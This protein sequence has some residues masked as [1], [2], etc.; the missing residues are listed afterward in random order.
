[1]DAIIW[2]LHAMPILLE[3]T[4]ATTIS[5]FRGIEIPQEPTLYDRYRNMKTGSQ[6]IFSISDA[7][8]RV[9]PAVVD[10]NSQSF[11]D[12]QALAMVT[13]VAEL[14]IINKE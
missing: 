12:L 10:R 11:K 2:T 8:A 14:L 13:E 7:F 9:S 3:K 5:K 4:V 1:M 6:A